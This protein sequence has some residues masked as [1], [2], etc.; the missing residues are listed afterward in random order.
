LSLFLGLNGLSGQVLN[1]QKDS[2]NAEQ[3]V[4]KL[5]DLVTFEANNTPDWEAVKSLF[6]EEATVVLRVSRTGHKIFSRQGFVD[7]F[8]NF[9]DQSKVDQTGFVEKIVSLKIMEMG[10]IAHG[11]VVYEVSIPGSPRPPQQGVDSFQLLKKDGQWLIVSIVNEIPTA[12]KP[13]PEGIL[14][15]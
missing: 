12:E 13:V 8:Q 14:K 4:R 5:Y 11:W 10:N 9:I 7:D 1:V 15:Q 3:V 2:V 6:V